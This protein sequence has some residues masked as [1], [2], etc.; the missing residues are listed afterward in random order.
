ML[1]QVFAV[2]I[3]IAMFVFIVTEIVERHVVSL[4]CALLTVVFVFGVG[5]HSMAAVIE[6]VN[7]QSIFTADF[8]YLSG[9]SAESSAGIN[10]ETILFI[11]GMMV[12]VEGMARAGFF[13]WLCMRIAKLVKYQ[14]IPLFV[15]FM[16]LST[17]L[18][19]FIDSITVILFLAAVTIELSQLLKFNPVPMILSEIFCANLGG[20][21]TMCGDPPNIIIG[22]SLGYSFTDFVT[23]TGLIAGISLIAVLV[24]FYL[25]FG[26]ELK[27]GAQEAVDYGSLPSPE[28]TI[29]DRKGFVV[30]SIIFGA[31]I[32]LLVTHAQTGLTVSAIGTIVAAATL[33]TSWRHAVTLLRKVDY[34]TLLFFIGLF[35]V[36]G[37]LEQTGTLEIMAAFIGRISGGNVMVMIAI[38]IWLSAVASAFV[39]NIPFATTMIP[40]IRTLSVTYGVDLSMLAWTLAMGTDIGGSATPIGASANVVGIATAAREGYVIRW[41][42][43]C[44][45]MMPATVIV[46]LISMLIIYV[47]YV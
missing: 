3:F 37:G 7:L 24:Y 4:V 34:K 30:S 21:A 28:S 47:R 11:F 27:T 31:A 15:T 17:V 6:T 2:I 43:Y 13:R 32:V 14:V 22:T 33:V 19:M 41:G 35:V 23:N 36:I 1:A 20:S 5:M 25:L 9:E 8:W 38:I 39:D 45:K 16:V 42:Q 29:T 44:K 46:V 40:I 18:A 26:R 10:W 12:M